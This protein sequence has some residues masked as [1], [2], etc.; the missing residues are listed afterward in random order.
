MATDFSSYLLESMTPQQQADTIA[1]IQAEQDANGG[2]NLQAPEI[3][4]AQPWTPEKVAQYKAEAKSEYDAAWNK[5]LSEGRDPSHDPAVIEAARVLNDKVTGA[6]NVGAYGGSGAGPMRTT[7]TPGVQNQ[8]NIIGA[9]TK[10]NANAIS[11]LQGTA[12]ATLAANRAELARQGGIID[13]MDPVYGDYVSQ[14]QDLATQLGRSAGAANGASTQSLAA[15]TSGLRDLNSRNDAAISSLGGVYDNLSTPLQS[16]ANIA[17]PQALAAQQNALGM[18]GS[19][20][21]G[22][23][24]YTSVAASAYADPKYTAMRDE[25]L[26]DLRGVSRG[27]KDVHVGQEDPAAY[28]SAMQALMKAGSLTNPGVTAAEQLIYEKARQDQEM[29]ERGLSSA[30]MSDL[31]RR[32]MAGGGA[33]LT[34]N[35]LDSARISQDRT[36]TDL[37]AAAGAV[38][39]SN[40]M[41]QL[42]GQLAS[43][44]NAQGNQLATSNADRQLAALGL[45][46]TGA[47]RAQESSFDQTYKRGV[48][49]DTASANNQQTRLQGQVGYANQANTMQDDAFQRNSWKDSFDQKERDALW[50]RTT[51]KTALTLNANSQ[52]S[53]N[54]SNIFSGEQGVINGNY[55]R[56]K[57]VISAV[58]LA[59]T[60]KVQGADKQTDR[61]LGLSG[62]TIGVNNSGLQNDASIVGMTIGNN[63]WN[64]TNLIKN[65]QVAMGRSDANK[66]AMD[67]ELAAADQQDRADSEGIFGLP[68]IGS[69]KGLLGGFGIGQESLDDKKAAIRAKYQGQGV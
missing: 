42:Q 9:T 12:D 43:G 60:R 66:A 10:R 52:N 17:D 48:A 18:L 69:R 16:T 7:T 31:R 6:D 1:K 15:Y 53:N 61:R 59:N 3:Q 8:N 54:M 57:D 4:Q 49:A 5:S 41:L 29:Q 14:T 46:E 34:Q 13:S 20:A 65:D 21:A 30:R 26:S 51:D 19:T 23:L 55:S 2:H 40:Q 32:G 33:E 11:G 62:E 44:L 28:A 64:G 63:T 68:I 45:F 56:D 36:L 24:D 50:G 35:A 39:R 22:G 27:S 58:D 47:E 25:G 67:A 37:G 38:Q